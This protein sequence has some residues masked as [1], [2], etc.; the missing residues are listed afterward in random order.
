MTLSTQAI[1][2]L[3]FLAP[4]LSFVAGFY[5]GVYRNRIGVEP[6]ALRSILVFLVILVTAAAAHIV[7]LIL[8]AVLNATMAGLGAA[9]TLPNP[10]A[11]MFVGTLPQTEAALTWSVLA[12][13]ASTIVLAALNFGLGRQAFH[14]LDSTARADILGVDMDFG[15]VRSSGDS[16]TPVAAFVLTGLT[17]EGQVFGY[18]GIVSNIVVGP[19][20]IITSISMV[21]AQAFSIDLSDAQWKRTARGAPVSKL[22]L[23]ADKIENIAFKAYELVPGD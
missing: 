21:E 22:V 20:N 7:G 3:L 18:G 6:P 14:R 2:T 5:N 9:G 10:Y 12:A 8:F 16:D 17:H 4:G 11:A 23:G 13:L 1:L 19:N 15:I